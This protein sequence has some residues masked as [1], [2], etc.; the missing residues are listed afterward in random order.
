MSRKNVWAEW[1]LILGMGLGLLAPVAAA[2]DL[3]YSAGIPSDGKAPVARYYEGNLS[4]LRN[5]LIDLRAMN[6]QAAAALRPAWEELQ[7]REDRAV[8]A[9]ALQ[10][11]FGGTLLL[12]SF[13][14]LREK[15]SDNSGG[16]TYQMSGSAA[17]LG[18]LFV[19]TA[20]IVYDILAPSRADILSFI[21]LHN[22]T[23]P[24]NPLHYRLDPTVA[25]GDTQPAG[26]VVPF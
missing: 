3:L 23:L 19:A 11:G 4:G 5:Y 2:E 17:V 14:F 12:G 26:L 16:T 10:A 20:F 24:A 1:V 7:D 8:V 13:S 21:N 18:V 15:V 9:G 22:E 6:P 25:G